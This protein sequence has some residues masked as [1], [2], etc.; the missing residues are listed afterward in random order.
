MILVDHRGEVVSPKPESCI[1]ASPDCTSLYLTADLQDNL[2]S[3]FYNVIL[4]PI[5]LSHPVLFRLIGL[6]KAEPDM[7]DDVDLPSSVVAVDHI[8]ELFKGMMAVLRHKICPECADR[9]LLAPLKVK[10]RQEPCQ[11]RAKANID[12]SKVL[13]SVLNPSHPVQLLRV[14]IKLGL[15]FRC[16]PCLKVSCHL[17]C[18]RTK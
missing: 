2:I 15:L 3:P 9:P 17:K 16:S 1:T 8:F 5:N 6:L 4:T 14:S 10:V 7:D 12:T 11:F 18:W 13:D